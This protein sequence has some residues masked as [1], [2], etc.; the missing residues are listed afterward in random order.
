[1]PLTHLAIE[2]FS[3]FG[4]AELELASGVNVF[5]GE[6]ATGKTH[7]GKTHAMKAIYAGLRAH[8]EEGSALSH[9][10]LREQGVLL[11]DEPEANLNPRLVVLVADVLVSLAAI[12]VQNLELRFSDEARVLHWDADDAYKRGR[13]RC[14]RHEGS[15]L[16]PAV[17][18]G[19]GGRGG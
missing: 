19:N 1:M 9:G 5:I 4:K 14:Q 3:A 12:G 15:R 13:R 16:L 8:G 6:N 11:W 7:A 10:S 2:D 17:G 18:R